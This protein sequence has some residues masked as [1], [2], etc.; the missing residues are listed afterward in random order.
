M[1]KLKFV[2]LLLSTLTLA[3]L[4]HY[5]SEARKEITAGSLLQPQPNFKIVDNSNYMPVGTHSNAL[6]NFKGTIKFPDHLMISKPAKISKDLVLDKNPQAF[7]AVRLSFISHGS[8][9]IPVERNIIFP[10]DG[11]SFWQMLVAPGKIWSEPSDLGWSRA[12]FPF[13]LM[14]VFENDTHN[15][16]MTFLFKDQQISMVRYQIVQQTL[17]FLIEKIFTAWGQVPVQFEA[18]N[19]PNET[20]IIAD[21]I[22][23]SKAR[24]QVKPLNKLKSLVPEEIFE[25]F[26]G[27]TKPKERIV[28][29]LVKDKVIYSRACRT[30]AGDYPYCSY[31]HQ[32]IWSATKSAGGALSMFRLA[33]KYGPE[34]F[35]YKI[36]DY[37]DVTATHNGWDNMTFADVLNMASGLGR[38]TLETNP[39]D[40]EDGN[41]YD[42]QYMEWYLAPNLKKKMK[43]VMEEPAY[44]WGP[45]VHARYRDYDPFTLSVAMDHLL[46]EREGQNKKLWDMMQEEV[47]RPIGIYHLA[48]NHTLDKNDNSS[49]PLMAYG[50]YLDLDSLAKISTL[51]QNRGVWN[52]EKILHP[53]SV[54]K[55]LKLRPGTG[56]TTAWEIPAG[57]YLYYNYFWHMPF[58]TQQGC[59]VTVPVMQ[60][61]GGVLISLMPNGITGFRIGI[62]D[63]YE[64]DIVWDS[65]SMAQ[66]AE[67]ITPFSCN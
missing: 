12:S 8:D 10:Q 36:K 59:H 21:F 27:G 25:N 37:I 65:T 30:E 53:N 31:M 64:N 9:L 20:Q 38:G 42:D 1:N 56:F 6:H 58:V 2:A 24:W 41:E 18:S 60:G 19:I 52:G 26:D 22:S 23:E 67:A 35:N 50:M 57:E 62:N 28:S 43:W 55:A 39:N 33:Q 48:H 7:P 34:V 47:F 40:I 16:L 51:L 32:G 14:N 46:K 4:T 17:P 13:T 44:P 15:G 3:A 49:V 11:N 29:G 63:D 5:Q 54:D 66:F 61:W 45:N